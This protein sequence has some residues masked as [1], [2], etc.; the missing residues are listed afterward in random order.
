MSEKTAISYETVVAL[1]VIDDAL[2][3]EYRKAMT[4]ILKKF[5]GGFRY[6]FKVQET[7]INES[8]NPINRVFLIFFKNQERKDSF[9][10]DPEYLKVREK[11]FNPSVG[12]TT[13]LSE[14]DR[15]S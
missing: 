5:E 7:L 3:T 2:Y 8:G 15:F 13:V 9:F 4:P 12:S 10:S 6:D 14:Y 11:Y 1:N